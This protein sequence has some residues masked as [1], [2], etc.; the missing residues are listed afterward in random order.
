[1]AQTG[2]AMS[3]CLRH[4]GSSIEMNRIRSGLS[5]GDELAESAGRS[6]KPGS[7]LPGQA[8]IHGVYIIIQR[9]EIDAMSF[10]RPRP[11]A[12]VARMSEAISGVFAF[13]ATPAIAFARAGYLLHGS[14]R[15][16]ATPFNGAALDEVL[17]ILGSHVLT[18]EPPHCRA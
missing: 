12:G 16:A 1:M 2:V 4:G 14:G 8:H 18:I 15:G 17:R 9:F 7:A 3:C 5:E 11:V 13:A 6:G 10:E